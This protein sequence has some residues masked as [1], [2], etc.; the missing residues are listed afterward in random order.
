MLYITTGFQLVSQTLAWSI[1]VDHP[2]SQIQ[3]LGRG[4]HQVKELL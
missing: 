1:Q 4:K 3:L 2:V